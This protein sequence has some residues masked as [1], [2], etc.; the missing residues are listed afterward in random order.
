MG[1]FGEPLG[2]WSGPK[3]IK[4]HRKTFINQ[5]S[6]IRYS[7]LSASDTRNEPL[8]LQVINFLIMVKTHFDREGY[9][10]TSSE[11]Y[12]LDDENLYVHLTNNAV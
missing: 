5:Q 3:S 1:S 10:R 8:F 6:E 4:I 2:T 9:I 11:I 12:D 7:C